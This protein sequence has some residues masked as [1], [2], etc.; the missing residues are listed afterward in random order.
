M[1]F[2]R[3]A[4]FSVLD[5]IWAMLPMTPMVQGHFKVLNGVARTLKKKYAHQSETTGSSSGSLQ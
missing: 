4:S 1:V 5:N 3:F 2:E